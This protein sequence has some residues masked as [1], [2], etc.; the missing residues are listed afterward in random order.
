MKNFAIY[1]NLGSA[2]QKLSRYNEAITNY[3]KA[4]SLNSQ[5]ATRYYNIGLCY[6]A[7]DSLDNSIIVLKKA[8]ELN[9]DYYE[10]YYEIGESYFLKQE[11]EN[12]KQYLQTIA[13]KQPQFA[14]IDKVHSML[15]VANQ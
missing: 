13:N 4:I 2:Y 15:A 10:C 12:A 1:N 7:V 3:K 11:Y 8:L 9:K 5:E 6:K 14:Q